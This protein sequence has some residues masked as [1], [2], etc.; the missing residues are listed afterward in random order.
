MFFSGGEMSFIKPILPFLNVVMALLA[1]LLFAMDL[2]ALELRL[3]TPSIAA[4]INDA[5]LN[6]GEWRTGM[7]TGGDD[8]Q[9]E[10]SA[11]RRK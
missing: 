7:S 11:Q 6:H 2:V 5:R 10:F 9:M 4:S 8:G 3:E 1:V